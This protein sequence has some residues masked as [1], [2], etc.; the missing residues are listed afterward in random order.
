MINLEWRTFWIILAIAWSL[1]WKSWGLWK[2]ARNKQRIWFMSMI[3][4]QSVG[5]LPILYIF[6]FQKNKNN[7]KSKILKRLHSIKFYA[8]FKT[9]KS[10]RKR[11][12]RKTK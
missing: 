6:F 12:S 3:I 4:I 5:I 9:R 7:R 10:F 2:A 1:P 11:K 8:L